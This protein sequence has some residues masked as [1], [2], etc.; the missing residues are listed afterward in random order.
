MNE[1]VSLLLFSITLSYLLVRLILL[2]AA[3]WSL[4]QAPNHRSS[5]EQPTPNGGGLGIVVSVTLVMAYLVIYGATQLWPLLA[6]GLPLALAG[7]LDDVR[8]ISAKWRFL[9]QVSVVAGLL[10]TLGDLPPLFIWGEIS[11]KGW[12]LLGFLF[13]VCAWWINE[14]NFMD[15]TDGIAGAQAISMLLAA[16]ALS[17]WGDSNVTDRLAITNPIFAL[18]LCVVAACFGFLILNWPPAKIFMG[19]VGS[20]WLAFVIFA[21]ALLTVQAGW[22]N[23]AAWAVLAAVFIIDSSVTLLTRITRGERWYEAHRS[24]AY[25]R[26]SRRWH[27]ERKVGHRSVA[28]LLI[29]INL[30]WLTPLA[31]ACM[32]WP[33]WVLPLVVLAYLPLLVCTF[34]LGAGRPDATAIQ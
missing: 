10:M 1:V 3:R 25:Q 13:L 6:F 20:T 32:V 17:F 28:W 8:E 15:G 31:W 26:L 2:L 24:H 22:L 19:D 14:F 5:H 9:V 16:V 18:M 12:L 11:L 29:T 23:Y 21:L 30:F 34:A 7:V 27:G 4:V 33:E